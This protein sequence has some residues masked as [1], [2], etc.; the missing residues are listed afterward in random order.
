MKIIFFGTP[1]F[2]I[3]SLESIL[4][5]NLE[6]LSV[7]TNPDKKSGRGLRKQSSPVKVFCTNRGIDFISFDNFNDVEACNYLK[8]FK[9]YIK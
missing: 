7:V 8:S 9:P 3:P 4:A 1:D 5:S 2:A 6:L